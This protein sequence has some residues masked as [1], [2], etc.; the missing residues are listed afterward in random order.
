VRLAAGRVPVIASAVGWHET[1]TQIDAVKAMADT[2]VTATVLL[3]SLI[4]GEAMDNGTWESRLD[5][6]LAGTGD[7]PL[8]FYEVPRPYKRSIAPEILGRAAATGRILFHKDTCHDMALMKAKIAATAGTGMKFFTTQMGSLVEVIEA[9]GH[10]FS[11]YAAN[12]YPELVQWVAVN[13]RENRETALRV[14]RLLAIAEHSINSKYP[15]SAKYFLRAN[16]G[17]DL[18]I[19]CRSICDTLSMHD[20]LPLDALIEIVRQADLPVEIVTSVRRAA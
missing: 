18:S 14:Q 20:R 1:D 5:T 3:P 11:S 10:G 6:I 13:A 4:A 2:G 16:A 19:R 8:G 12:L 15:A 17:I 7:I 9:G